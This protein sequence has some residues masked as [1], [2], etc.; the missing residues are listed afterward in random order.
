MQSVVVAEK[1]DNYSRQALLGMS[2]ASAQC[3]SVFST[4][5]DPFRVPFLFSG[6]T[7]PL[8][9]YVKA[10]NTSRRKSATTISEAV[11]LS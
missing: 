4:T 6:P 1:I 9:A 2:S 7:R 3:F 10:E 5:T 8:S 11:L